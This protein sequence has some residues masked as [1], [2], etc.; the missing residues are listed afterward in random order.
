MA[1]T[2]GHTKFGKA[3]SLPENARPARVICSEGASSAG[4]GTEP[5]AQFTLGQVIRRTARL[6]PH[7]PA[8]VSAT[9]AP[10]TY[11]DLQ[12][13][14][15][16]IRLQLRL[17]GFDCNARIG[18][19]MPN[20]PEV[21]L[22]IVAVACCSIAVPFDP[23]LSPAEIDQRLDMLRLSALLV[24]QG[25]AFEARRAAKR[26]GLA[27]IEAAPVGHG[28]LGLDIAV[29]VSDSPAIET[30]PDPAAPAFILQTSGTTAQPKL[31]PFSHRNM[32]AA[33][34]RSQAWFGLTP[35]DRC[36]TV[37]PP[38]Y[39]HGLT[40]TVFTPLLTGGSIAVPANSAIVA[41]DEWLDELRP[42]WYSAGP[43]LHMAVLDKARSLENA[44]AAHT[45]RFVVS[46]GAPLPQEV[47]DGLQRILG[48]P[49]LE[50]YG[51]SEASLI[52][53]NQPPPGPNRLGTCGQP[54]PGTV[55]IVGEDG[56]PLPVG[57]RV[58]SGFV[59][60]T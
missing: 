45:L 4:D 57:E 34:A 33:A 14:L 20:G 41:L 35:R 24:P 10:L 36:L 7:Q 46:G 25:C 40:V 51:S 37:S 23:R 17:A 27:I 58:R 8:I 13:Q 26:R 12:H 2:D 1:G 9:F 49:V 43:T 47:R 21:V 15:D 6:F 11:H 50:H 22:T 19:L 5:G 42:T 32:L 59:A 18:L 38:Y 30:E 28:Q 29:Q 56:L 54:W 60:P 31:I 16:D 55:A 44:Q 53:A 39:S 52:A 48:V 3:N